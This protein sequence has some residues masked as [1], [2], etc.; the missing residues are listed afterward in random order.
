MTPAQVKS[1]VTN[2]FGPAAKVQEGANTADGTQ[3]IL[4]TVDH[5]D[6]GPGPAQIGYVFGATS[7]TLSTINVVWSTAADPTEQQRAAI[8]QAGQQLAAY[9][10]SGPA[11]AKVAGLATF[12]TNGLRLYAAADKKNAG[13]EVLI[14]GVAYQ[15]TGGDKPIASP[16]PKGPATLRVSYTQDVEKPDIK[17]LKPGSF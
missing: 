6:P 3:F 1:A 9:F 8:A 13:V 10:Q 17:A 16:P 14:D 11:P 7:K 2:D 12:G 5:L 15:G 4:V